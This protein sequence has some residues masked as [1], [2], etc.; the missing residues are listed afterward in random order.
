MG[1]DVTICRFSQNINLTVNPILLHVLTGQ[2]TLGCP[3]NS[4]TLHHTYI[5]YCGSL[6]SWICWRIFHWK[7]EKHRGHWRW[8]EANSTFRTSN[9][10]EHTWRRD[11]SKHLWFSSERRCW[12]ANRF[13]GECKLEMERHMRKPVRGST[14]TWEA[15]ER[16]QFQFQNNTAI[17]SRIFQVLH[18]YSKFSN[19][20]GVADVNE[21]LSIKNLFL[22]GEFSRNF[23]WWKRK[24]SHV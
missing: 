15:V 13:A 20:W 10:Q 9:P 11:A 16:I 3:I 8:T 19:F 24:Y 12:N 4:Y 17:W 7:S 5:L 2:F 21:G 14:W 18:F 22:V 1:E 6:K 23:R